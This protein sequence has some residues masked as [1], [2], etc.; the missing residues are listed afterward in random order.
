M[1]HLLRRYLRSQVAD[2]REH[3][4]QANH[5]EPGNILE[6]T[7]ADGPLILDGLETPPDLDAIL[8]DIPPQDIMNKL[9]SRYFNGVE[10]PTGTFSD[11][12]VVS[13]KD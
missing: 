9:V 6:T 5:L 12:P 2:I 4:D 11:T 1:C 10:F 3:F 13:S 8:S 7:F